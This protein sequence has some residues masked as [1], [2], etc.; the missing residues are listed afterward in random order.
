M[1]V[2]VNDQPAALPV[3]LCAP[4]PIAAARL[5]SL[6]SQQGSPA[7]ALQQHDH[8]AET[9]VSQGFH[10]TVYEIRRYF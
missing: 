6:R 8:L 7:A 3:A 1:L 4:Q 2:V 9:G 5:E 10:W